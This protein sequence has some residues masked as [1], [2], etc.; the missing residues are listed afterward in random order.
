MSN[1]ETVTTWTDGSGRWHARVNFPA[2]GYNGDTINTNAK[3][4]R[5]RARRT[6]RRELMERQNL[7]PGYR[8]QIEL[9]S[10]VVDADM[11][12]SITYAEVITEHDESEYQ[13]PKV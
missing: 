13:R 6:I 7:R 12:K 3:R 2:P 9:I 11:F 5:A 4:I 1:Q 10:D 8:L